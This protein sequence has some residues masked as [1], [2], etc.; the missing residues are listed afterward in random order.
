MAEAIT[1][2]EYRQRLATQMT[3]GAPAKAIAF[4]SFGDGGHNTDLTP[5]TPNHIAILPN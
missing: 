1:S 5:I 4:M 3:G 2:T